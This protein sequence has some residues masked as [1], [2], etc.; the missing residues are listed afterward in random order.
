MTKLEANGATSTRLLYSATNL[1]IKQT[2][3]IAS[4]AVAFGSISVMSSKIWT[5]LCGVHDEA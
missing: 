1:S 4:T 3:A 5:E 2:H